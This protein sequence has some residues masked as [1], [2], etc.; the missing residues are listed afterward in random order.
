[1]RL[2]SF[3]FSSFFFPVGANLSASWLQSSKRV[4]TEK[5]REI[6]RWS[7]GG[8]RAMCVE[9]ERWCDG[10]VQRERQDRRGGGE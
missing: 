1:M 8:W 5:R 4:Q 2:S 6:E 9:E 3:L 7:E 10:G